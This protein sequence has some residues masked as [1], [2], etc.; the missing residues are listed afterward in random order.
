MHVE[1]LFTE[2]V[3]KKFGDHYTKYLCLLKNLSGPG[4]C[5][6]VDGVLACEPKGCQFESQSGHMPG[7]R[8]GP[9]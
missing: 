3:V 5:G 2:R 6:S 4:C 9:Q 8:P 1:K 7:F